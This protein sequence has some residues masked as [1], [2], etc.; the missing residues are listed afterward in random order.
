MALKPLLV[1]LTGG[2]ASGKS[3]VCARL[4]ELGARIVDADMVAREVVQPG[5]PGLSEIAEAFGPGVLDAD[6]KLDRAALRAIVF[7]DPTQRQRLEAILHPRI[8]ARMRTQAERADSAYCVLAIPLLVESGAAYDWV[9]CVVV[10]D[11]SEP[12]QLARV[13][14]RDRIS[15]PLAR[16]MIAAQASRTQRLALADE[17]VSNEGSIAQLLA[18]TDALHQ[19]LLR[20]ADSRH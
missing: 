5:E 1:A 11:V 15:E 7:N 12:V 17:I 16:Q 3:T 9:D 19:R 14:A 18:A 8:R 6:R 20:R 13:M 2:I 4:A 10:V